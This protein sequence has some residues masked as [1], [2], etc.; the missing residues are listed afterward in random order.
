MI[1]VV[2]HSVSLDQHLDCPVHFQ[3]QQQYFTPSPSS[4][5]TTTPSLT[6]SANNLDF[7]SASFGG[8]DLTGEQF[9]A[10]PLSACVNF[11]DIQN[12]PTNI[13][14]MTFPLQPYQQSAQGLPNSSTS[15]S[16]H[17]NDMT[18]TTT[19]HHQ[20]VDEASAQQAAMLQQPDVTTPSFVEPSTNYFALPA[21]T[22]SSLQSASYYSPP[23]S[24]PPQANPIISNLATE[25]NNLNGSR[26]TG[27]YIG[28]FQTQSHPRMR[29]TSNT[30]TAQ[31]IAAGTDFTPSHHY[32]P[33]REIY[34]DT[35]PTS[36]GRVN[37]Q[38]HHQKSISVIGATNNYSRQ[39]NVTAAPLPLT[40]TTSIA[41]QINSPSSSGVW[42]TKT[43]STHSSPSLETAA[44]PTTPTYYS[45]PPRSYYSRLPLYDRPFKCDQCPQN[46]KKIDESS[47][48]Q[49]N[50]SSPIKSYVD[51]EISVKSEST[52]EGAYNTYET[53]SI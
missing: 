24:L 34:H 33:Q 39:Q 23:S 12:W 16:R 13:F 41:P 29:M 30:T 20:F 22:S 43:S 14:E 8:F 42:S 38:A 7:N 48:K 53:S 17:F 26:N 45:G 18:S 40:V 36:I 35:V 4:F 37:A 31:L 51:G 32:L 9:I 10:R 47:T 44:S 27:G 46:D 21:A 2:A 19:F 15:S 49:K 52:K 5:A 6:T 50:T 28:N 11:L 3:Q 25:T 1:D